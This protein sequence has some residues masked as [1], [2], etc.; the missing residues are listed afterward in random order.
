MHVYALGKRSS[1]MSVFMEKMRDAGVPPAAPAAVLSEMS[2][3]WPSR[4][5]RDLHAWDMEQMSL[6]DL[7]AVYHISRV[8]WTLPKSSRRL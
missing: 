4:A 6:L 2:V 5:P 3:S 8:F 7:L 1:V